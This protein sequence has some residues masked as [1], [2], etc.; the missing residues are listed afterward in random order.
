MRA[1]EKLMREFVKVADLHEK[2]SRIFQAFKLNPRSNL[3]STK[4]LYGNTPE[5][6]QDIVNPDRMALIISDKNEDFLRSLHGGSDAL[7]ILKLNKAVK[8]LPF[9]FITGLPYEKSYKRLIMFNR[10]LR[11]FIILA[12]LV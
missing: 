10:Y 5:S 8:R 7:R 4:S 2:I 9:T 12:S 1:G 6:Y 11:D 3:E